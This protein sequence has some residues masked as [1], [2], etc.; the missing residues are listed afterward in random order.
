MEL[1]VQDQKQPT[2]KPH[3]GR[4]GPWK[5]PPQ[6]SRLSH[7]SVPTSAE[8]SARA[9]LG[10]LLGSKS[11]AAFSRL[12]HSTKCQPRQSSGLQCT[13]LLGLKPRALASILMNRDRTFSKVQSNFCETTFFLTY[14]ARHDLIGSD[15]ITKNVAQH[16][17]TNREREKVDFLAKH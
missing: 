3:S 12:A 17:K 6:L 5:R 8:P 10:H 11:V 7:G 15:V 2:Q 1:V 14:G 4:R 9:S 13:R 16:F